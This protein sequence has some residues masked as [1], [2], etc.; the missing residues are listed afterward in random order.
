MPVPPEMWQRLPIWAHEP[1]V[2]QVSIMLPS[3][4][5]APT[6]RKQGISTTPG[7]T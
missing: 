5:K 6:L 7:A 2:A 1:T 4:T 3:S